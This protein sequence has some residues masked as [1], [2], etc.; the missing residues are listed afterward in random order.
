MEGKDD[1][2]FRSLKMRMGDRTEGMRILNIVIN[3]GMTKRKMISAY[4][5]DLELNLLNLFKYLFK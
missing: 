3:K 5:P 1:Y 2:I 4:P